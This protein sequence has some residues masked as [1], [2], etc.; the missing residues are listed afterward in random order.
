MESKRNNHLFIA[1][2][3]KLAIKQGQFTLVKH[4]IEFVVRS[5]N[6]KFV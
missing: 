1:Y 6:L 5:E 4:I 3:S 2:K